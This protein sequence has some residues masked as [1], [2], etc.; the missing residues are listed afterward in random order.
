LNT[1]PDDERQGLDEGGYQKAEQHKGRGF[2][3]DNPR[4]A[5]ESGE[6]V[7]IVSCVPGRMCATRQGVGVWRALAGPR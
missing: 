5:G 4:F 2:I 3:E 1:D 7:H 6:K